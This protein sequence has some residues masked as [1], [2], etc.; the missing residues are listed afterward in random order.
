VAATRIFP[1]LVFLVVACG[2]TAPSAESGPATGG[3]TCQ[4]D[5]SCAGGSF[6][7]RGTCVNEYPTRHYGWACDPAKL[8]T[9]EEIAEDPLLAGKLNPCGAYVCQELRCR[10][11]TTDSDCASGKCY[12]ASADDTEQPGWVCGVPPS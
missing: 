11:C 9:P 5:S 1:W 8:P 6:C 10:S 2:S 3:K 4:D 12:E 7:D